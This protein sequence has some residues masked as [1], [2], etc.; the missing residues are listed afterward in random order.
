MPNQ[1][2]KVFHGEHLQFTMGMR[3]MKD[4]RDR[5]CCGAA[6]RRRGCNYLSQI[7]TLHLPFNY[8]DRLNTDDRTCSAGRIIVYRPAGKPLFLLVNAVDHEFSISIRSA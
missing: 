1:L 2:A 7:F 6:S 8:L 5:N 3:G 4:P